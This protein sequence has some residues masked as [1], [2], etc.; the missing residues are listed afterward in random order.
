MTALFSDMALL[1]G[2][3]VGPVYVG[4]VAMP[5]VTA[6]TLV[7]TPIGGVQAGDQIFCFAFNSVGAAATVTTR[8]SGFTNILT[9]SNAD[10]GNAII[11][12]KIATSSEPSSYSWV[13][14]NAGSVVTAVM[15]AI[16][17]GA[18]L[19][20]APSAFDANTSANQVLTSITAPSTG[21]LIGF[22]SIRN[23]SASI[24]TPPGG[25]TQRASTIGLASTIPLVAFDQN[26]TGAGPTGSRTLVW[27]ASATVV[28]ALI[29]AY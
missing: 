28:G 14:N 17:G 4:G 5:R 7:V 29:H 13:W 16:R 26:P 19:F 24:S 3:K 27:S 10:G 23:G 1:M 25:M 20:S 2:G 21:V 15:I 6:T 9:R 18:A 22:F 8:P 12:R 11:D